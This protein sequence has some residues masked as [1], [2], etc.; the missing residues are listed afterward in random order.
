[1]DRGDYSAALG[2]STVGAVSGRIALGCGV[3]LLGA[4]TTAAG[5]GVILDVVGAILL[6]VGWLIN[7]FTTDS[8]LEL[9]VAHSVWGAHHGE[10]RGEKSWSD[11]PFE[12][13]HE[14]KPDGLAHQVRALYNVLEAFSVKGV[15]RNI[16]IQLGRTDPKSILQLKLETEHSER[17]VSVEMELDIAAGKIGRATGYSVIPKVKFGERTL[18]INWLLAEDP[19]LQDGR[20]VHGRPMDCSVRLDYYGDWQAPDSGFPQWAGIPH[21]VGHRERSGQ[22][23]GWWRLGIPTAAFAVLRSPSITSRHRMP[24]VRPRAYQGQF[25]V[26]RLI[27]L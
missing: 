17:K 26:A 1:M 27:P 5:V 19:V 10:G 2:Y 3:T 16:T 22:Q 4:E 14:R 15:R 20:H 24:M 7:L 18:E 9:F 25:V 8:D 6:A 12:S 21:R 23:P 11:G 13:W